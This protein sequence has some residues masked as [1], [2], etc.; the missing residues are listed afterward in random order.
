M[1]FA[2]VSV[3]MFFAILVLNVRLKTPGHIATVRTYFSPRDIT[4]DVLSSDGFQQPRCIRGVVLQSVLSRS[5][6]CG[7]LKTFAIAVR[8]TRLKGHLL[9]W[10]KLYRCK[11]SNL[12]PELH[13]LVGGLVYVFCS[14]TRNRS[15]T[16]PFLA[17]VWWRRWS[18]SLYRQWSWTSYYCVEVWFVWLEA[19]Y[20]RRHWG[21]GGSELPE[22]DRWCK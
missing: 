11:Q 10:P 19:R 17:S 6:S 12:S 1:K 4:F 5:L 18:H 8:R 9:C 2:F 3:L 22:F 16:H 20:A 21:H 15:I 7:S 13:P 14:L